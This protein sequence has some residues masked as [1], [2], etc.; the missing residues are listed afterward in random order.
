M[1]WRNETG[2]RCVSCYMRKALCVCDVIPKLD[3]KTKVVLLMHKRELRTTTNTGRLALV[4]LTNS[5]LH[6]R[7]GQESPNYSHLINSSRIP[8]LLY[9]DEDAIELSMEWISGLKKEVTLFVPDGSW[10]QASKVG[11]REVALRGIQKVKLPAGGPASQY[12]LRREPK[13]DGLAT[14][15]AL[16]RAMGFFEGAE[17]Q[18]QLEKLFTCMVERMLWSRGS[19]KTEECTWPIPINSTEDIANYKDT[20]RS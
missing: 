8:L 7:G 1:A 5:E 14:F 12:R 2:T 6:I 16:A 20:L 18:K 13:K 10:R 17:T 4:S 3:L 19:L 9:P 11:N 15:E